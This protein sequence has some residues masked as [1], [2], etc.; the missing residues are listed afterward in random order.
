M[1]NCDGH[2]GRG[3]PREF[4]PVGSEAPMLQLKLSWSTDSRSPITPRLCSSCPLRTWPSSQ[5]RV[6]LE[7][8]VACRRGAYALIPLAAHHL[9]SVAPFWPGISK[10]SLLL[11]QQPHSQPL[12]HAAGR[13]ALLSVQ[14]QALA[15]FEFSRVQEVSAQR[16]NHELRC[17]RRRIRQRPQVSII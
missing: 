3:A 4:R 10:Y 5:T 1:N 8:V 12:Q 17:I 7:A 13:L 14:L 2:P 16:D 15:R 6:A 9:D 11:Y